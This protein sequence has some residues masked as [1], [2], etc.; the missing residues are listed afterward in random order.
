MVRGLPIVVTCIEYFF[1]ERDLLALGFEY[2]ILHLV[3][4]VQFGDDLE[5]ISLFVSL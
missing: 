4:S 2:E 1:E 5:C 3:D